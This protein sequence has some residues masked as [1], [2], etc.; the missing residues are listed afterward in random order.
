M[1]NLQAGPFFATMSGMSKHNQ[2]GSINVLLIP[3]ILVTA[4][5]LAA[6][7]FGVW[8]F[9]SRQDYKNNVDQ[10]IASA[11]RIAVQQESTKKDKEFAE[12]EKQ[13]LKAYNGPEAYGSLVVQYPKTWSSYVDDTGNAS[14]AVDGYFY[15]GTVPSLTAQ[16]STFALRIQVLAQQYATVLNN[17][18]GQLQN[19]K[20]TASPFKLAKVPSVVGLR[21][22]GQITGTKT[23]SMIVLPLRDKTLEI[24]TESS[25][26]S[27]DF[28]NNILPNLSFSP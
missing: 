23:G 8:A 24:W 21:L 3:F 16:S 25:Q 19:G 15:P 10:K 14:A 2:D 11:E 6:L 28:N 27:N 12:I 7:A 18:S 1:S 5:L 26:Y 4:L 13:P 9:G 20:L 22:D 17:F